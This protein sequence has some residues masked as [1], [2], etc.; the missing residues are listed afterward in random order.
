LS[1]LAPIKV[2]LKEMFDA[3]KI[4]RNPGHDDCINKIR[5]SLNILL[6]LKY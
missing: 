4:G 2:D 3:P 5:V 6:N 1:A